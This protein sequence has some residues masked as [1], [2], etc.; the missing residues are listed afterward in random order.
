MEKMKQKLKIV[1]YNE[2]HAGGVADMWNNSREGWG[3]DSLI[4]TEEKVKTQEANSSNLNLYLAMEDDLVV[5]YCGLSEYREDEGA[6]YIPLLNVRTDYHGKK[7]GKQLVLTALERAV[8]L[9]WPRLDLYTWPGNTKA[10]PLYKRC[11]FF[12][13]DRD[14]TTH[15]MNFI[16]TV[17]QTEAVSE[18]FLTNNWYETSTREIEVSPDGRKEND[19]TY[20]E[21]KWEDQTQTLRMEFERTG[22]GLRLIETNDYLISCEVENFKLVSD[23]SY[24]VNYHVKNKTGLPLQIDF[25]GENHKQI[26]FPF[27][28]SIHV[29]GE[30]IIEATFHLKKFEEEQSNW[31]THP[32][33]IT[34]LLINGKRARFAIGVLPKQPAKIKGVVPG[35]QCYLNE[36]GVFYLD[37]ENNYQEEATF[38][39]HFPKSNWV[40]LEKEKYILNVASKA[41]VSIPVSYVLKEFGFYSPV[42]D[43]DV[44]T[45]TGITTNFKKEVGIA[46]KGLGARFSGECEQYWHIYNGLYHLYLSK[47]DNKIIPGR[48]TTD[49][50]NTFS[51]FPK[52]GKPYSSEFSKRK[53]H[54][55]H[56]DENH[57]AITLYADYQSSDFPGLEIVSMSKL[58]AEG[59]VEQSYKLRNHNDHLS[60]NETWVYQPIYHNFYKP[61]LPMNQQIIEVNEQASADYGIWNSKNFTESWLFSRHTPYAHGISWPKDAKV[62]FE[63]WYM[64]IEHNLGKIKPN[65]E[66]ETKPVY[67]SFGAYQSWE[68]F[69]DF[70]NR[71]TFDAVTPVEDLILTGL[72]DKNHDVD[73]HFVDQKEGHLH[74][75][76]QLHYGNVTVDREFTQTDEKSS[77]VQKFESSADSLSTV[78]ASFE[79]NGVQSSKQ[80]LVL[81]PRDGEVNICTENREGHEVF[82]ATNGLLSISAAASFYP[83][84]FSLHAHGKEWLHSSFPSLE[85]RAWWNPWSGGIRTSIQGANHKSFAKED[86]TITVASLVDDSNMKW[87]GIKITTTFKQHEEY[88]GLEIKQYYVM[89]PNVPILAHVTKFVQHTGTYFHHK[90]W[91][92]E[93]CLKAGNLLEDSWIKSNDEKG[94]YFAGRTEIVSMLNQHVLIGSTTDQHVLQLITDPATV[95]TETYM[96]K[97]V[98]SIAAWHLLSLAHGKEWISSPSFYVAKDTILSNDEVKQLQRIQ[99]REV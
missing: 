43:V 78:K 38:T 96:N 21:Y 51:M 32:S 31:R 18:Y 46:F 55:V 73:I 23:A 24:K 83:G 94:K 28:Q 58:Y 91:F 95:E 50:Q 99:L 39:I 4:T 35:S 34:N 9:G 54:R 47:F 53:P 69:R 5:G 36:Q 44:Q 98:Q 76:I 42:L 10:V 67:V 65:T 59:L 60:E 77:T 75:I 49:S 12:W 70:A 87:Q 33:V 92:A 81:P 16:P 82:V 14:D 84:L 80:A 71:K 72:Y 15:L 88:S 1:E 45:K 93:T 97:E 6:L 20:Y 3:G 66:V 27:K 26:E 90:K 52:I 29:Q 30:T 57:G 85:P 41:K 61:V 74:G 17:L 63:N 68:E 62:N 8:E 86:T 56:Y 89:L 7:I 11:G 40:D 19:F 48:L 25:E 2:N 37:I 64:Y 22:R 79:L 13:E